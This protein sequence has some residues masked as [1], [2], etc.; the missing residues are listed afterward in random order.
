MPTFNADFDS[1][2]PSTPERP[3]GRRGYHLNNSLTTDPS[4]TP[5]GP[6]TAAPVS[7]TPAGPPP[8]TPFGSSLLAPGNTTSRSQPLFGHAPSAVGAPIPATNAANIGQRGPVFNGRTINETP[9][10]PMWFASTNKD[11]TADD[12][13]E[14]EM[15]DENEH[16]EDQDNQM[17]E[18]Q[19]YEDD[20]ESLE[21]DD[22]AM[23]ED[24]LP[25]SLYG[26]H[27]GAIPASSRT[28]RHLLALQAHPTPLKESSK[29]SRPEP[30]VEPPLE[31]SPAIHQ[32]P[33]PFSDV[34]RK[35]TATVR[36]APL[37]E[38]DDMILGTEELLSRLD[39]NVTNSRGYR[40][41]SSESLSQ[42]SEELLKWWE[43]F[44][45]TVQRQP[46]KSRIGLHEQDSPIAKAMYLVSL[47]LPLHHPPP[48]T[49]SN[50]PSSN[51]PMP[52]P[53][54]LLGWL[55]TQHH[56]TSELISQIQ[57]QRPNPSHHA[58]FWEG[59][60]SAVL[61]GKLDEAIDVMQRADF[62]PS[63]ALSDSISSQ[64][65][66]A[67]E[68]QQYIEN[69]MG[70]AIQILKQCPAVRQAD[71]SLT[72]SNWAVFRLQVSQASR[73]LQALIEETPPMENEPGA[74]SF[75]AEHFGIH[76]Q[77]S[78]GL[79]F[80]T[81]S[82]MARSKLP[83][84]MYENLQLLY[85]IMCGNVAD[86]LVS[87]QDWVEATI[88][89][90][91]WWDGQS[92]SV[93]PQQSQSRQD[94]DDV[95]EILQLDA[96]LGARYLDR[97]YQ[98]FHLVTDSSNRDD[99]R[100]STVNP[101]EL[102]LAAVLIGDVEGVVAQL[103]GWSLVMASAVVRLGRRGGWLDP[104]SYDQMMNEFD[105]SDLMVLNYEQPGVRSW[106]DDVLVD[107]ARALRD[108]ESLQ[109]EIPV[110]DESTKQDSTVEVVR[111]GW[112]L[113]I[114]VLARL[115]SSETANG[116]IGEVLDQLPLETEEQVDQ[117]ITM[118]RELGQGT[119]ARKIAERYAD[120]LAEDSDSYGTTLIYY[121]RAHQ[122][123]KLKSVVDML[124]SYCLVQSTSYPPERELDD[125]LRDLIESPKE[126][127]S[128]LAQSD[129]DA[130]ELLQY[131][132]SGYAS[133]RKFY[134]LRDEGVKSRAGGK[135]PTRE[136]MRKKTAL[137]VLL[138]LIGSASD[139]IHGGLYDEGR[140]SV[141]SVDGLL[142]LLGESLVFIDQP[143]RYL[144]LA[145]VFDLLK[146][147][148]DLQ[149][150]APRI[151]TLCED[152][153][154]TSLSS[155]RGS[156]V[157]SPKTTLKKSLSSLT[158]STNFSMIGS[159]MLE[160]RPNG[161][162]EGSGVLVTGEIQRGWDWRMSLRPNVTGKEVLQM[163]RLRLANELSRGWLAGDEVV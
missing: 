73:D 12:Q 126:T 156:Q 95:N 51:T 4:T 155:A 48:S 76:N 71:W 17:D 133:L 145:Q 87:A 25:R 65:G 110:V 27:S 45:V 35:S 28:A 57:S 10:T 8:S 31:D 19:E 24:Q 115:S 97:L 119:Q 60:L 13:D 79:A 137:G 42:I 94:Q 104:S 77:K 102:G 21:G 80:A 116:K 15:D 89:L 37:H 40:S 18:D 5:A 47:L 148:E 149:T 143:K 141:I 62:R 91:A 109:G 162:T 68:R 41:N 161:M 100:V 6:P 146:A 135:P 63:D 3:Q 130:A 129:R 138:A 38:F 131:Q 158:A 134:D 59:T 103:R 56:P 14:V 142:I 114:Q 121:A 112:E 61:R 9:P 58:Y 147:I 90:T 30:D 46:D 118:C 33:S 163:L 69:A 151:Y 82:R 23:D 122:R 20:D 75:S 99:F 127:L 136:L 70:S 49:V 154:K 64:S 144:S 124:V 44:L 39:W 29:K 32:I 140:G 113:C 34:I 7:F 36:S 92:E 78:Q 86:I 98:S 26:G 72:S 120:S 150:I 74:S 128:A 96:N 83:L 107:Y 125:H 81:A 66:S 54:I 67:E 93:P 153:F 53:R 159:S 117:L 132:M 22:D 11:E 52:Y 2:P 157:S 160:S 105:Q 123:K 88:G 111:D 1:S 16:E 43:P 152:L 55:N 108:H 106:K 101:V 139:S 85:G 84:N 50:M